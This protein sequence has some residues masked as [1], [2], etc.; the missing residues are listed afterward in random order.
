MRA[1]VGG[2]AASSINKAL[3]ADQMRARALAGARKPRAYGTWYVACGRF[4]N[5]RAYLQTIVWTAIGTPVLYLFA[6]GIGLG[7]LVSRGTGTIDG[8]RY[9]QFVAPALIV[10][11]A[12]QVASEEMTYPVM[13]GFKWNPTFFATNAAPIQ[14]AQI[15]NGLIVSV[16]GRLAFA[17][18]IYYACA[19]AFGAHGSGWGWLAI[20]IAVLAALAFTTPVMAYV[21]T[22]E[23]DSGQI[24]MIMRFVVMPLTL[25]SGTFFDLASMPIYLQPI[26]WLSPIWHGAQLARAASYGLGEP[27]WVTAIRVAYL[28][29]LTAG[30]WI[31]GQRIAAR[32]LNR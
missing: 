19:V 23:Q 8:V 6:M 1:D 9:V 2:G 3:T 24:A 28:I 14:P 7:S 17:S 29:A 22:L 4:A 26:G 25:F 16:I 15:I 5:M 27:A 32:R 21:A 13:L 20:P 31:A 30:G 11:A 10:A 12:V 18:A